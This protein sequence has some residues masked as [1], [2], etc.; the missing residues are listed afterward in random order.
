MTS[1]E[2][3]IKLHQLNLKQTSLAG[4][5]KKSEPHIWRAIHT[6]YYPTLRQKIENYIIKK[7]NSLKNKEA[8]K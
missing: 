1:K 2:I 3:I 4:I 8:T 7:E 5:F 6:T